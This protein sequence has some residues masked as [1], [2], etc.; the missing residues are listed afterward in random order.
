M[1]LTDSEELGA[2]ET[3]ACLSEGSQN[4]EEI[5]KGVIEEKFETNED[6]FEEI[7][8]EWKSAKDFKLSTFLT[9]LFLAAFAAF[10]LASDSFLFVEYLGK[11]LELEANRTLSIQNESNTFDSNQSTNTEP[12]FRPNPEPNDQNNR[13]YAILTLLIQFLPGIQWY[14][15]ITTKHKLLRFLTTIFFPFFTVIFKVTVLMT[16]ILLT[17]VVRSEVLSTKDRRLPRQSKG[18]AVLRQSVNP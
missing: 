10:S 14:T 1:G 3:Q 2:E 17:F 16:T 9:R 11:G 15:S 13:V 6:H 4:A 12:R 7:L 18:C 8:D 5:E